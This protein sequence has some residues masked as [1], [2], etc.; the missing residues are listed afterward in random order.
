MAESTIAAVAQWIAQFDSTQS[1][2]RACATAS[3]LL[4]GILLFDALAEL[5][6]DHFD[7]S[8]LTQPVDEHNTMQQLGNMRALVKSM[9]ALLTDSYETMC[10]N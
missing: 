7:R 2:Q 8:L 1:S 10:L 4:D 9:E 6:P 3:D 5:A